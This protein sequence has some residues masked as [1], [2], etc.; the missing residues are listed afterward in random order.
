MLGESKPVLDR[1]ENFLW[2]K[3]YHTV[4][5]NLQTILVEVLYNDKLYQT[6]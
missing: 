4:L 1:E 3:R 6:L 5:T 2:E